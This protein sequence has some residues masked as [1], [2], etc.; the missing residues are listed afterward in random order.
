MGTTTRQ[1]GNTLTKWLL[2][3]HSFNF[4]QAVRLI[5]RLSIKDKTEHSVYFKAKPALNFAFADISHAKANPKK[6]NYGIDLYQS[7][8][9]LCGQNAILPEHFM[10]L[11]TSL[12]FTILH[13]I[14][15][16]YIDIFMAT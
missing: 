13:Y 1:Q 4:F 2:S 10:E 14:V 6:A 16:M 3:A 9:G 8:M 12:D 11:S 5:K 15:I 7:F